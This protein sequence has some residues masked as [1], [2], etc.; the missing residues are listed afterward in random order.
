M[1]KI[2]PGN[3]DAYGK[4]LHNVLCFY[5]YENWFARIKR[6]MKVKGTVLTKLYRERGVFDFKEHSVYYWYKKF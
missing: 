5:H 6:R 2:N 1:K 4:S 3:T